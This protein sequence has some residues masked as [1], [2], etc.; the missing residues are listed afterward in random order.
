MLFCSV[1]FIYYT[2]SFPLWHTSVFFF[3]LVYG[4]YASRLKLLQKMSNK[5]NACSQDQVGMEWNLSFWAGSCSYAKLHAQASSMLI[6]TAHYSANQGTVGNLSLLP[7][8]FLEL[9]S[10]SVF[11]TSSPILHIIWY[12]TS[13]FCVKAHTGH[14]NTPQ[15]PGSKEH[16]LLCVR[17]IH[18]ALTQ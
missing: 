13:T 4:I 5:R 9:F 8:T 7:L 11:L 2:K 18:R 14:I 16:R 12:W 3:P 17:I 15:K 6:H 10:A 1:G